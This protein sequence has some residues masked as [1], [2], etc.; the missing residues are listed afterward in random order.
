VAQLDE[1]LS[2][3]AEEFRKLVS[4]VSQDLRRLAADLGEQLQILTEELRK[5]SRAPGGFEPAP[6][7]KIRELADLRDEGV[8]TEEEFQE[9][10]KKLLA[11][12]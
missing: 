12:V 4:D 9:Q 7:E 6:I 10:K 2:R 8:I 3:R 5:R 1:E 11:Q